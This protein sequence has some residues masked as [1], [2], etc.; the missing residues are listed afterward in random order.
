[1]TPSPACFALVWA[2]CS[3]IYLTGQD[4][5]VK[6]ERHG[7]KQGENQ[8]QRHAMPSESKNTEGQLRRCLFPSWGCFHI[9]FVSIHYPS[10]TPQTQRAGRPCWA[11]AGSCKCSPPSPL[12]SQISKCQ[13]L[14]QIWAIGK[15]QE[16]F[17]RWDKYDHTVNLILRELAG[18]VEQGQVHASVVHPVHSPPPLETTIINIIIVAII[19]VIVTTLHFFCVF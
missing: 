17:Q 16:R 12:I 6:K 10:S 9:C 1:M 18:F 2:F 7:Q 15:P 19:I 11:R 8:N 14:R 4:V 5:T 3:D 13:K